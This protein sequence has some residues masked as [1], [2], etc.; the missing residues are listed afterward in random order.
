MGVDHGGFDIF[1]AEEFLDGADVV[2][3]LEEVGGEGVAKGM[4]GDVFVDAGFLG[5]IFDG[6]L[7]SGG[8]EVVTAGK[9][10]IPSFPHLGE[11][12]PIPPPIR[13]RNGGGVSREV[14]GEF[15]GGEEVLPDPVRRW[16]WGIFLRGHSGGKPVQSRQPGLPDGG[17]ERV[18]S[19]V[20]G[21]G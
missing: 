15:G 8:F 1:V 11:I 5:G 2:A 6:A 10:S 9:T 4:R 3:V 19:G 21:A 7:E 14:L 16:R 17:G 18:R 12:D 13:T 20:E